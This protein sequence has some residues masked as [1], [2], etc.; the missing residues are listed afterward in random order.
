MTSFHSCDNIVQGKKEWICIEVESA[1]GTE[2]SIPISVN[3][4]DQIE[5]SG[6]LSITVPQGI[7]NAY[8]FVRDGPAFPANWDFNEEPILRFRTMQR[9]TPS[10]RI[11]NF[12]LVWR[13][14]VY[15]GWNYHGYGDVGSGVT[16][17]EWMEYEIDLRIALDGVVSP[18]QLGMVAQLYFVIEA[19]T[20]GVEVLI[21][22]FETFSATTPP[23]LFITIEPESVI[24]NENTIVNLV[25]TPYGGMPPYEIIW[26]VNG[27]IVQEGMDTSYTFFAESTG[28][29]NI[30]VTV[31][32]SSG[33]IY[34][35][36][37]SIIVLRPIPPP[38]PA[39]PLHVSGNK[40]LNDRLEQIQLKGANIAGFIDG[41]NA[42]WLD[43]SGVW[44]WGVS[45]VWDSNW[46]REQL[47]GMRSWGMNCV[48]THLSVEL[49][50]YNIDFMIDKYKEFL[51]IAQEL[52]IYVIADFFSI[53]YYGQPGVQ[54]N[55][56]PYPP[57]LN[58]EE[59][60]ML[61][62][63]VGHPWTEQDF[64]EFYTKFANDLRVFPNVLY[65]FWNE[66]HGDDMDEEMWFSMSQQLI[67]SIRAEGISNIILIQWDYSMTLKYDGSTIPP[68]QPLL[69]ESTPM[70][71]VFKYP[72][73]D[74]SNNLA[75]STHLYRYY[76]SPGWFSPSGLWTDR[77]PFYREEEQKQIFADGLLTEVGK[78]YPIIIGE[79]GMALDGSYPAPDGLDA[80]EAE[81]LAFINLLQIC[82]DYKWGY[83]AFWFRPGGTFRLVQSGIPGYIPFESGS[84]LI[85]HMRATDI[86]S[87]IKI[88]ELII[89]TT[90]IVGGLYYLSRRRRK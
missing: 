80:T 43:K 46:V 8:L 69:E 13:D 64:I 26:R 36:T 72:L 79:L 86:V 31:T 84:I 49:W 37:A 10:P 71:W 85:D 28:N 53:R 75:Y 24:T 76:G 81:K 19:Y 21:D 29:Y 39:R 77:L 54:A 50:M 58:T 4:I 57:Y 78:R 68:A 22:G 27:N 3:T 2:T 23:P 12:G 44:H 35:D 14:D 56:A 73:S 88:S 63:A 32:D 38:K 9:N 7:Y 6:C 87:P 70:D 17:G 30:E 89:G 34:S 25:S 52:G 66:S 40:I 60:A 65:E 41:P 59:Q 5:G 83:I 15:S 82:N 16:L 48:R 47:D 62:T 20:V 55:A 45:G 90:V 42:N 61:D 67:N 1:P 74:P 33:A 11:I 18:P 51:A